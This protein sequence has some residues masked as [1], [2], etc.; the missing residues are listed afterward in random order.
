MIAET[1]SQYELTPFPLSLYRNKDQ[2]MNKANISKTSL[3]ALTDPL[4]LTNQPCCTLVIDSGWHLYQVKWEYQTWQEIA[5]SYLRAV[6]GPLL[7]ED[8]DCDF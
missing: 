4:D 5:N 3:K 1:S 7:S 8:K 6:S 2:N